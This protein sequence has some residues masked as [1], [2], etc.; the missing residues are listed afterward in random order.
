MGVKYNKD[1]DIEILINKTLWDIIN[2]YDRQRRGWWESITTDDGLPPPEVLT[3]DEYT[4]EFLGLENE[5]ERNGTVESGKSA[6]TNLKSPGILGYAVKTSRIFLYTL[7]QDHQACSCTTNVEQFINPP[8]PS[9][10]K[11]LLHWG[12][13]LLVS[14]GISYIMHF[15]PQAV[16]ES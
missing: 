11:P 15:D 5:E 16:Q 6:T 9:P 14:A 3:Y 2:L 10:L 1:K 7:P 8:T 4:F 12:L 13:V